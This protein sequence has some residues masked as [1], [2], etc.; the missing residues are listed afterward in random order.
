MDKNFSNLTWTESTILS[1]FFDKEGNHHVFVSDDC[2]TVVEAGKAL[3]NNKDSKD[4]FGIDAYGLL[5]LKPIKPIIEAMKNMGF[6]V[7]QRKTRVNGVQTAYYTASLNEAI[8][9]LV[10]KEALT[11]AQR[12]Q[13]YR[14]KIESMGVVQESIYVHND[15]K[16]ALRIYAA[17]LRQARGCSLPT[18]SK[19]LSQGIEDA[20]DV[21]TG[22]LPND[23]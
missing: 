20:A 8:K 22:K 5:R 11:N 9:P 21:L 14:E 23:D 2:S 19:I 1:A 18:D 7:K 6:D 4:Y 12:K 3:L 17:Q 10:K 16:Q 15:D 13:A